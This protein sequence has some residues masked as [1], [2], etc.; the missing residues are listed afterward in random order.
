M[1]SIENLFEIVE[2][3][4]VCLDNICLLTYKSELKSVSP[5]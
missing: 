4:E 5:C 1:I 3:K 2:S